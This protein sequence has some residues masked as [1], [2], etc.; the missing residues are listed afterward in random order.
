MYTSPKVCYWHVSMAPHRRF[1]MDPNIFWEGPCQKYTHEAYPRK[2]FWVYTRS[3]QGKVWCVEPSRGYFSGTPHHAFIY[4]HL[5]NPGTIVGPQIVV[6]RFQCDFAGF[7]GIFLLTSGGG[8]P[9]CRA[10]FSSLLFM[11]WR[12]W[13][14]ADRD[15]SQSI[16]FEEFLLFFYRFLG[17]Q[18]GHHGQK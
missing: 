3:F 9:Y 16:S 11:I 4:H 13:A 5:E 7:T 17:R 14:E 6:S 15:R 1:P 18:R 10:I 8:G 12:F 2:V